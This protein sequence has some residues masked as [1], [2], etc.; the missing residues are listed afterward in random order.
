MKS[1]EQ[2]HISRKLDQCIFN[3]RKEEGKASQQGPVHQQNVPQVSG[4]TL[5]KPQK[6]QFL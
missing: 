6:E 1:T 4:I 3:S 5:H 2:L